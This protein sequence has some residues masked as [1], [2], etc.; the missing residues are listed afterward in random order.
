VRTLRISTVKMACPR[1]GRIYSS[2]FVSKLKLRRANSTQTG[3]DTSRNRYRFPITVLFFVFSIV[4]IRFPAFS[5]YSHLD[6]FRIFIFIGVV[7]D[8]FFFIFSFDL[9]PA[10]ETP[11]ESRPSVFF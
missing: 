8:S 7:R 1:S 11:E 3:Y 10:G 9:E 4:L 6:G 2:I 5:D